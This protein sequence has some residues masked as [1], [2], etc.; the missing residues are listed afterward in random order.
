M[1]Q[2]LF[3]GITEAKE[4]AEVQSR[5]KAVYLKRHSLKIKAGFHALAGNVP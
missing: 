5:A 2:F 3:P 4:K 1:L